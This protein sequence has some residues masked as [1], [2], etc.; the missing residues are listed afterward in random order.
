MA[1][2]TLAASPPQELPGARRVLILLLAINLFNYI[3]RFVL[4]AVAPKIELAFLQ[5]DPDPKFKIGLLSLAFMIAYMVLAPIFGWLADR[6]SRWFLI[7]IGVILWSLASGAS[8]LSVLFVGIT[9]YWILLV[10][11]CFVGVGEAAYGPAAPTLISDVF[12]VRIRGQVMAFFYAAIPVGAALGY[13]FGGLVDKWLG[14]QW[15]FYLVVP[16][17]IFLGILCLFMPEPGRGEADK[18][19]DQPAGPPHE[20]VPSAPHPTGLQAYR[21]LAKIPSYVLNTLGMTAMTFA[22]GGLSFWMPGYVSDREGKCLV[23]QKIVDELTS[24]ENPL[25]ADVVL[26]LRPLMDK[27]IPLPKFRKQAEEVLGKEAWRKYGETLINECCDPSLAW[28][29]TLFGGIVLIS[30]LTAT[31]LGGW[32]GDRL[33][34]RFPG[35]YFLTSG[36][37]M[38]VGFPMVILVLV[39]PFPLAWIFVFLAVF[40][41]MFNTGPTNT[42]L[43]NTTPASIRSTGFALNI[44]IIHVLGDAISPAIMGTIADHWSMDIAMGVVSAV[45]LLGGVFWLWGVKHLERDTAL[46][47]ARS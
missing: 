24:S 15:A 35:S 18:L 20:T 4:V 37:A 2:A 16:P 40:F 33:K 27:E 23:T 3:D 28:I 25:P 12:S 22:L 32:L 26:K 47:T 11:R 31:L 41:L 14:W 10:T 36:L 6:G 9:G 43:A 45:V 38:F 8:G 7:A 17:G 1:H 44:F 39:L 42:I 21:D 29:N 30:G 46:A 5:N 19:L 34:K 13:V